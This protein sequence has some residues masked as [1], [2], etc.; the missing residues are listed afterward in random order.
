MV[1]YN[2]NTLC[3]I[4]NSDNFSYQNSVTALNDIRNY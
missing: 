2:I 4:F 1:E 3:D